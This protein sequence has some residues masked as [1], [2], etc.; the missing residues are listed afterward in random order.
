MR[1]LLL[2]RGSAGVGKSTYIKEHD[3]EQ[4]ALSADNIRL[5]CQSP[6]L[7]TDGSMAIS[8]TNEK[9]VW[10]LLFQMLEA[11]MQRGEFVVIDATNSKTQE[12]NRYKDMAK[13]YRYRIFCVDMTGVPMEE[14]KRR[15]KL[16]PL[17]KQVPD[18]VIEK[19]YARFETQAIPAGVTVIQPDEL[20]KIWYKP[21]D[22]SHYKKIHHIGD[23]HGCYTVLQEYL[24]DGFKDNEL[25]I[26]C[27]DY[28][29]RGIENVEV[30]KFLFSIMDKPNVILLEGNHERWLWY[31]AHGGT[32][33]SKEF[34]NVTRRQLEAGGLDSKVARMLYRKLNQ[35]VYYRFGEKTVLVTHAGLSLIPD[36]LTKVA[37]E[38]M[39]RGVG[40]YGDYLDVATTFDQT[41]PKNTYQIFGHRNTEDSPITMSERCFNLEGAVE[42]GGCLRAVVLDADGFH[43]VMIQ[44]TVFRQQEEVAPV[45]Y[46][47]EEKSVMDVVDKLR[48]NRYIYEKQL[49]NISSFNFT[50]D[51]FYDK[52]W[53]EQTTK[54][55]GLFID[56]ANGV[57]VARSYPKFFN[58]NER[59]E[60]RFGMLQY[61]LKFPV[62]AYVKENG[63]LGMVSYNPE[64]DD[65]FIASKSTT[66]GD[67]AGWLRD[68]FFK[69][70]KNPDKL[71]DYLK[72][73]NVTLVFECVDM[74]NDPHIIKYDTSHLFLLD[75]VKNQL[76]FE[77]LPYAQVLE[78]GNEYGFEVKTKAVQLQNWHEFRDWY[79]DVLAEDYQF[80]GRII[81]G[82]VVEDSV[83][84]MVKIKLD[85]YKLWKH[86]RGVAQSVFRSGYY[87]R[88]GSLLT[89]LQNQF[90]GFCQEIAKQE[91]H[92]T[93]IIELRDM[94]FKQANNNIS[95]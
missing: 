64:T 77:K 18:E 55:R 9:L 29:D 19:M 36:N 70:V 20:D 85:Y 23:I 7:Q 86:M 14:C 45:G 42:R 71:K 61:K 87:R 83:G 60:T 90:Y 72:R 91:D 22:Y 24:K 50:R 59:P 63:F 66:E 6:V 39:I 44:N 57:V 92:P 68:M 93:N 2:L 25:Y 40:R 4:Y 89:P 28:I 16:R 3:L 69:N 47:T 79:N 26:F 78:L 56:T 17:Y 21:S 30:I 52:K 88:M 76:D 41:M 48:Q 1:V 75:V 94:F 5:M 27:G 84:F 58:V 12:I 67:F 34:E 74:A 38:Q 81:E 35:C 54:A 37:S 11:R 82:F 31:W 95:K 49:G 32:S 8:Q 46:T 62:T 80:N 43:P 51:A 53:N 33:Q 13:T 65:F 73:K 10:N 15:N